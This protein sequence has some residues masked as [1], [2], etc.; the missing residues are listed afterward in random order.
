M[1]EVNDSAA[2][3]WEIDH[4]AGGQVFKPVYMVVVRRKSQPGKSVV[5]VSS[6]NFMSVRKYEEQLNSDLYLLSNNEFVRKY[7]LH[8]L[9]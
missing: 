8:N 2:D 7:G 9:T 5:K 3:W 6:S 4:Q 1:S